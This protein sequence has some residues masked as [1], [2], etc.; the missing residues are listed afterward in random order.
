MWGLTWALILFAPRRA[1]SFHFPPL[2]QNLSQPRLWW[3][4]LVARTQTRF[5]ALLSETMLRLASIPPGRL[6]PQ[7]K[8]RKKALVPTAKALHRALSQALARGDV[9]ALRKTAMPVLYASLAAK[10]QQRRRGRRFEWTLLRYTATPRLLIHTVEQMP[11]D[12]TG[13]ATL[14]TRQAVV[15][16]ASRQRLVEY[17]DVKGRGVVVSE[18][19]VDLVERIIIMAIVDQGTYETGEWKVWGFGE[20]AT[21]DEY[22]SARAFM[23]Q[24]QKDEAAKQKA[25]LRSIS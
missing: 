21:L 2:L 13:T 17:D 1:V 9:S 5:N 6:R 10:M 18:K 8:L 25:K 15:S 14:V 23:R 11:L 19:E 12:T 22:Q 3:R 24:M 16:I 20:E 4:L 7:L